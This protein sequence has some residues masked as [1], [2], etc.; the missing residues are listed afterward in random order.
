MRKPI[1]V[2]LDTDIGGDIDDSWAL[3][4]LLNS[5]E[6]KV[7]LIT[8]ATDNTDHRTAITAKMLAAAR[9][10]DVPI[11]TGI[12]KNGNP[13]QVSP[14]IA[15]FDVCSYKGNIYPDGVDAMVRTIMDAKETITLISI[16]PLTNVA[17]ALTKE[18]RI[19]QRARFVGMQG[20]IEKHHGDTD[21]AI[22]E[23]NIVRDLEAAKAVFGASW[24]MTITPLDTCGNVILEGEFYRRVVASQ[25]PLT[26]ALIKARYFS[27][28]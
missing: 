23:Y 27:T 11:G 13:V 6:L 25:A 4:M 22:A 9:R 3:A 18:P 10:F 8:T 14:W 16:G 15:D 5:P 26:K 1:P 19:A 24:D 21:G 7:E 28:R 2:I 17:A 12:K 20:S